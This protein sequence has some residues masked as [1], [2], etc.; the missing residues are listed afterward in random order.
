[1]ASLL[2]V[3]AAQAANLS[4]VLALSLQSDP[5]LREADAN[6]LAA[7]EA[8]PLARSVMLPQINLGYQKDYS[9]GDGTTQCDPTSALC[10][11]NTNTVPFEQT[12]DTDLLNLEL[13]Q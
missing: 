10:P 13:R 6:R 12:R 4:E 2:A 5:Q 11:P 8:K 1:L 7:H 9:N 3:P